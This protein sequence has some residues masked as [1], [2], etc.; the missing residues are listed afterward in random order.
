MLEAPV[1][2]ASVYGREAHL[3]G[4]WRELDEPVVME[5]GVHAQ[6]RWTACLLEAVSHDFPFSSTMTNPSETFS[7]ARGLPEF[8][9][10]E[11]AH[12]SLAPLASA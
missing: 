4:S 11:H 3:V 9:S 1:P 2:A 5:R 7:A 10:D 12:P 6:H 8:G